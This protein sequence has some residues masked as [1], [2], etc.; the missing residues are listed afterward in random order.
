MNEL[1]FSRLLTWESRQSSEKQLRLT[2]SI[3]PSMDSQ[4]IF[5]FVLYSL[6]VFGVEHP[7]CLREISQSPVKSHER[8]KVRISNSTLTTVSHEGIH[9]LDT[10]F[11]KGISKP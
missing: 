3:L 8:L 7:Y 11:Q 9:T 4:G 5:P 1:S 10:F 2:F 6:T